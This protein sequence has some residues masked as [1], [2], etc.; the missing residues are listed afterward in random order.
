MK[1]RLFTLC[2]C[3]LLLLSFVACEEERAPSA[4]PLENSPPAPSPQ[5][6]VKSE[7]AII[8]EFYT[9]DGFLKNSSFRI[10]IT[11]ENLTAPV[12]SIAYNLYNTST[13]GFYEM[14]YNFSKWE[15]G[16]WVL[17]PVKPYSP[18][19]EDGPI[20]VD[21]GPREKIPPT[22]VLPLTAMCDGT[23]YDPL[24]AGQY[25]LNVKIQVGYDVQDANTEFAEIYMTASFTVTAPAE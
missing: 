7:P 20:Y 19:E 10:E 11:E 4:N 15:D 5:S 1:K 17:I 12:S 22:P 3:L 14:G 8:G 2:L 25:R 23:K 18:P 13:C 6:P 21:R 24:E 16:E 9:E